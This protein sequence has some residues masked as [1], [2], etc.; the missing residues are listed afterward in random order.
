[1]S[2][3]RLTTRTRRRMARTTS[4]STS[5]WMSSDLCRTS[6]S[7]FIAHRLREQGNAFRTQ[8]V[9]KAPGQEPS[10]AGRVIPQTLQAVGFAMSVSRERT[11]SLWMSTD[12]LP[13]AAPLRQPDSADVL[14]IGSGIAG[15]SVAY[16]LS[17]RGQD[18]V[19]LDR[20]PIGK[21]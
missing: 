10:C 14:I 19:V 17:L 18:V 1:M 7:S 12:V 3:W 4:R 8:A 15:L 9:P 20:G 11:I 21:G 13:D 6:C 5:F 2:Y 16:E